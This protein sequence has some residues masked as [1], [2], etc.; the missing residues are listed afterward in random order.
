MIYF[1][2]LFQQNDA[3]LCYRWNIMHLQICLEMNIY[4]LFL[5][6][7]IRQ[8][9]ML[10]VRKLSPCKHSMKENKLWWVKR[11][12]KSTFIWILKIN[13]LLSFHFKN[14]QF[15]YLSIFISSLSSYKSAYNPHLPYF[16][17]CWK[18]HRTQSLTRMSWVAILVC[19]YLMVWL[20]LR[21]FG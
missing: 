13:D 14:V 20:L 21:T 15:V 1:L 4:C 2:R 7:L 11:R 12:S 3:F 5:S 8:L 10:T 9:W 16:R 18:I 19:H 6:H 17:Q